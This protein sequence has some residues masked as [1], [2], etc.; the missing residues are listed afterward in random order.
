LLFEYSLDVFRLAKE[1]GYFDTLPVA[2]VPSVASHFDE[3]PYAPKSA[4][5][6]R[7]MFL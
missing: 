1:E 2:E 4:M 7:M 6:C 3:G 5:H